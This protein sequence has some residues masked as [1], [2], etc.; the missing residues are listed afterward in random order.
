MTVPR[1]ARSGFLDSR[2]HQIR[3]EHIIRK[4]DLHSEVLDKHAKRGP[5]FAAAV[6]Q[7]QGL[8]RSRTIP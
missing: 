2:A 5:L 7:L 4:A 8:R 3:L 1:L 6:A